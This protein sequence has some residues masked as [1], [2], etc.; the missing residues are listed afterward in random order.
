M[1]QT[2]PKYY[3]AINLAALALPLVVWS[4]T[5]SKVLGIFELLQVLL[6]IG[7][8]IVFGI[9]VEK[10]ANNNSKKYIWGTLAFVTASLLSSYWIY[11]QYTTIT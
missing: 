11:L 6:V 8:I 3:T 2:K 9:I 5:S 10:I 1:N 7:F 4:I